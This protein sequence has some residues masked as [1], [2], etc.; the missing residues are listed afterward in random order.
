MKHILVTGGNGFLGK[1]ICSIASR[2]GIHAVSISRHGRPKHMAPDDYSLVQWVKAD[3]FNPVE[4][5]PY[6]KDCIAVIHCIGIAEEIPDRGITYEHMIYESAKIVAITAK[7]NNVHKLVY[8]SAGAPPPEASEGYMNNKIAAEKFLRSPELD[9][10][11]TILKPG[12]L[13]G[14][15]RPET[16]EENKEI[17]KLLQDPVIRKEIWPNR[18]LPVETVA[19]VALYSAMHTLDAADLYVDDIEHLSKKINL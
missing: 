10:D 1:S 17:Q 5:K 3:I 15:E 13:Y 2:N 8:I 19:R 14:L 9:F 16:I 12:M 18:P 4:W 6:L 11:L 7:A